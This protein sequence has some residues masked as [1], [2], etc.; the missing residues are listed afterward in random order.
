[1][2]RA[3]KGKSMVKVNTLRNSN[4]IKESNAIKTWAVIAFIVIVIAF[5]AYVFNG[6]GEGNEKNPLE[7]KKIINMNTT[8]TKVNEGARVISELYDIPVGAVIVSQCKNT[9]QDYNLT[10][11]DYKC[12]AD[13]KFLC[14]C[15]LDEQIEIM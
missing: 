6:A 14:Y 3:V 12:T 11:Y 10:L 4:A 7:N 2:A 5:G 8:C 1:M 13:D 9:C 15:N